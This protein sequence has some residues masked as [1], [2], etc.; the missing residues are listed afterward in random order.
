MKQIEV[1]NQQLIELEATESGIEIRTIS[2]KS[3]G[4]VTDFYDISD[5]DIITALNWVRYQKENGNKALL[6]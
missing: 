3:W 6:F 4:K 1:N 5:G 2:R